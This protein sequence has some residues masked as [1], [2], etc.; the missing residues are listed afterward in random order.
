MTP[1][2]SPQ[3][4]CCCPTYTT[5]PKVSI[6][7]GSGLN[8]HVPKPP[9]L[10]LKFH[11]KPAQLTMKESTCPTTTLLL[12][13]FPDQYNPILCEARWILEFM[14]LPA[15]NMS[16][17]TLEFISTGSQCHSDFLSQSLV[18]KC[19]IHSLH[20]QRPAAVCE[21]PLFIHLIYSVYSAVFAVR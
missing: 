12:K 19:S 9:Q 13:H 17:H 15:A 11:F 3:G 4:C 21:M 6:G 10:C 18:R 16:K 5:L 20:L 7:L 14:F 2:L 1:L 8:Y